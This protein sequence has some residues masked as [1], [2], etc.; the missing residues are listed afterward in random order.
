MDITHIILLLYM[1][2]YEMYTNRI[3]PL[4]GAHLIAA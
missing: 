1:G 3:D 2:M 4:V